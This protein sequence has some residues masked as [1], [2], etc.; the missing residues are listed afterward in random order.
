[1]TELAEK[2]AVGIAGL[3]LGLHEHYIGVAGQSEADRTQSLISREVCKASAMRLLDIIESMADN[4]CGHPSYFYVKPLKALFSIC[5]IYR[6]IKCPEDGWV[7][8]YGQRIDSVMATPCRNGNNA[9][10]FL[11]GKVNLILQYY[12]ETP[13]MKMNDSILKVMQK[14]SQPKELDRVSTPNIFDSQMFLEYVSLGTR[15]F[16]LMGTIACSISTPAC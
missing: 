7:Q 10:R 5:K 1:M 9:V 16:M 4:T 6:H 13:E 8:M 3:E 14:G 15:V 12:H 11:N 2:S